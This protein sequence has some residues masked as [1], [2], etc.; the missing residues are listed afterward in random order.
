MIHYGDK[1]ITAIYIGQRAFSA[2]YV[3]AKIVWSAISCCF[4]RGY[5]QG[6]KPWS[7]TDG[8]RSNIGK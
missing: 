4:G 2:V 6:N 1:E 7:R 3:G 8:W 5:W